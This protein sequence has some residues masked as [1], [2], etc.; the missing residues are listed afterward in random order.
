[1]E[2]QNLT[3]YRM[4]IIKKDTETSKAIVAFAAGALTLSSLV[5]V[6]NIVMNNDVTAFQVGGSTVALAAY[7][8]GYVKTIDLNNKE[9][10]RLKEETAKTKDYI[11]D[12]LGT[13]RYQLEKYN[14]KRNQSIIV[15]GGFFASA[16]GSIH[17]II[18]QPNPPIVIAGATMAALATIMSLLNLGLVKNYNNLGKI[19]GSEIAALEESQKLEAAA[20]EFFSSYP[21][22]EKEVTLKEEGSKLELHLPT[23]K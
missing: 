13:L 10:L 21:E 20:K 9:M 12:R 14:T 3:D 18:N 11:R 6:G 8:A 22:N 1:M 16:L 15:S 19:S 2:E 5:V 17:Q 4:E 7:T 23:K